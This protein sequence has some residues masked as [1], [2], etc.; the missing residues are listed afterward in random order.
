[1]SLRENYVLHACLSLRVSIVLQRLIPDYPKAL[2]S[3]RTKETMT[4]NAKQDYKIRTLAPPQR[5]RFQFHEEYFYSISCKQ[6]TQF[7]SHSL[8]PFCLD[9]PVHQGSLSGVTDRAVLFAGTAFSNTVR[10]NEDEVAF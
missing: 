4:K 7:V 1:M 5:A 10:M 8:S 9:A 3:M 6:V 2:L